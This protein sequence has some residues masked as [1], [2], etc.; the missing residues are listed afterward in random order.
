VTQEDLDSSVSKVKQIE[1][2]TGIRTVLV[3]TTEQETMPST[4]NIFD[5][6]LK[7]PRAFRFAVVVSE[8]QVTND[9]QH[10]LETVA[11]NRNISVKK[12][13]SKEKTLEWLKSEL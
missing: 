2:D 8:K 6:V 4:I 10:F 7:L 5:F 13:F 12:F 11:V 9:D 1:E 3:D